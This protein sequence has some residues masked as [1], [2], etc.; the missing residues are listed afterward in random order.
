VFG[1]RPSPDYPQC[2]YRLAR[3]RGRDKT[4]FLDQ[5]QE[6]GHAFQILLEAEVFIRR[7]TKLAGRILP[8]RM[9]REDTPEYPIE[10]VREALVNAICHRDYTI[11]GGA[12]SV[13]IFD[14]RL[15]IINTG[16]LATGVQIEDLKRDHESLPR[17]P[18][19]AEV[20]YRRGLI[21][22]W[23]RGTQKIIEICKAAGSP[24]PEFEERAGAVVVR[25]FPRPDRGGH[26]PPASRLTPRQQNIIDILR[27]TESVNPAQL[28][29]AVRPAVTDRTLR[30]DLDRL[31]ALGLVERTGKARA[32]RYHL[33]D[34]RERS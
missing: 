33:I 16:K 25:F 24:E 22:K 29:A 9:E 12:V 10:A 4:E 17:N 14:D 28:L 7:N 23:G 19:I 13:A 18:I 27:G 5:K 21:E 6:F 20:F 2:C 30:A 1:K 31:V 32:T 3:F 34:R 8:D 26:V 11:P 15:E